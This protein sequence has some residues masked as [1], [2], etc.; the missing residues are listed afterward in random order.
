L[1][2]L[3][4]RLLLT[5]LLCG[6]MTAQNSLDRKDREES[7]RLVWET[8]RDRYFDPSFGGTDWEAIRREMEPAALN[9]PDDA[10]FYDVLQRMVDRLGQSHFQVMPPFWVSTRQRAQKGSASAGIDLTATPEDQLL[11]R[12]VHPS[13]SE[14][15]PQ[16]KPGC[17]LLGAGD[18][19][20]TE[21]RREIR[22]Q[23]PDAHRAGVEF[24]ETASNALTGRYG[25]R[26]TIR[27]QCGSQSAQT[28]EVTL[29]SHAS[30]ERS[31]R[32]GHVPSLDTEFEVLHLPGNIVAV[33]FNLFVM[34]LL[35]RIRETIQQAAADGRAGIIFDV[36]GN[37]GGIGA[38]A[39]GIAGYLVKERSSLGVMKLRGTELKFMSFPQDDAFHGPV[40]VLI[41]R[42]SAST[43]EI[44]AAGLQ[45]LGRAIVVGERSMGAALP[46]FFTELPHG[47]MLQ[48]AVADYLTPKGARI[49]GRGVAPDVPAAMDAASLLNGVDPQLEA[50]RLALLRAAR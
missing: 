49:E 4:P 45:E 20:F 2:R 41:D 22:Q 44:F 16:L 38:M 39:N 15:V 1:Q 6:T 11:V 31:E 24:L 43:S 29:R 33:R 27:Y 14:S 32:M 28:S 35:P 8:V 46:S 40:A 5:L 18:T 50:A 17:T 48:F 3:L 21:L 26:L 47:A 7:F 42:T 9:A 10:A 19:S 30:G 34:S 25:E 37:P 12:R 23:F 13:L 36:R